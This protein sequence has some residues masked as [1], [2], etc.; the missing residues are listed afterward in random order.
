MNR[1]AVVILV[2]VFVLLLGGLFLGTL[3]FSIYT[4]QVSNPEASTGTITDNQAVVLFLITLAVMGHIVGF[5][6]T[7]Y[8][9]L[10]FFNREVSRAQKS[11]EKPFTLLADGSSEGTTLS[12]SVLMD[13]MLYIVIGAGVFMLAATIVVLLVA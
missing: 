9:V 5:G 6:A 11:P 12:R 7:L 10:W 2:G 1:T 3:D 4:P 8:A 13:N